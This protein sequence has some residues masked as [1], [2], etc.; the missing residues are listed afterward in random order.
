MGDMYGSGPQDGYGDPDA[1]GKRAREDDFQP[2]KRA[3]SGGPETVFRFLCDVKI[4]GGMIGKGGASIRDVQQNTGAFI[5]VIHEC[6]PHCTERVF[7]VGSPRDMM[8]G[9]FNA[10]QIAL[11]NLFDKQLNLERNGCPPGG[12]FLRYAPKPYFSGLRHSYSL[13][14]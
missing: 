7:V 8:D 5:Q 14:Y 1:Y 12:P 13:Y 2:N 4:V 3:A 10:A 11:F 9:Q 6:P